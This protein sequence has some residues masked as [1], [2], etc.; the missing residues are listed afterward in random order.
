MDYF[1]SSLQPHDVDTIIM[2]F[3]IDKEAEAERLVICL[4]YTA[5]KWQSLGSNIEL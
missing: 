4:G 3:N 5:I 1:I 2:P